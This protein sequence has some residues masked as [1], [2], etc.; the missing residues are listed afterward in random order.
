M[1]LQLSLFDLSVETD[2]ELEAQRCLTM[3]NNVTERLGTF[4]T[5]HK[6]SRLPNQHPLYA[7]ACLNSVNNSDGFVTVIL[8]GIAG[9]HIDRLKLLH[10]VICLVCFM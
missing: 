10:N 3:S 4:S 5:P 7:V 1:S 2:L 9:W 6:P 8:Y